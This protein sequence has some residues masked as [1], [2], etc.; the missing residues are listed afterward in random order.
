MYT[1]GLYHY[2]NSMTGR[3]TMLNN[4]DVIPIQKF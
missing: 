4:F 3:Y 2:D 1:G